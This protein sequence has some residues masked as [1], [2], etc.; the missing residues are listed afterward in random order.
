MSSLN[1]KSFPSAGLTNLTCLD[2]GGT[3]IT[4]GGLAHLR[5]MDNLE[6]LYLRQTRITDE[7]LAHLDGMENL[8]MLI[9]DQTRITGEGLAHLKGMTNLKWLFLGQTRVT[10]DGFAPYGRLFLGR[11]LAIRESG[12]GIAGPR[13]CPLRAFRPLGRAR[14]RPDQ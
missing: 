14:V 7:G 2:L 1:S 10:G 12:F 9:L 8:K 6:H 13:R 5:G 11:E 4:D 3:Q